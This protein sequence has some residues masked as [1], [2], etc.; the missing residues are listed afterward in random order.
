MATPKPRQ[1]QKK[2][3]NLLVSK[4]HNDTLTTNEKDDLVLLSI[5]KG[6]GN[7]ANTQTNVAAAARIRRA[8]DETKGGAAARRSR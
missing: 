1:A 6:N 4:L 5:L 3:Y 7:F 2:Q 8:L